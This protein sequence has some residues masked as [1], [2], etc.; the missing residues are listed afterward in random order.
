MRTKLSLQLHRQLPCLTPLGHL[1]HGSKVLAL[2]AVMETE[3]V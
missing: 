3:S 1:H 2:R